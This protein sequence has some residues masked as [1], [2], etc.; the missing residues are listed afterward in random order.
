MAIGD[1]CPSCCKGYNCPSAIGDARGF[2][3]TLAEPRR[4]IRT[5]YA[6]YGELKFPA[7]SG[8][9]RGQSRAGEIKSLQQAR[10]GR[11]GESPPSGRVIF[12]GQSQGREARSRLS[13]MRSRKAPCR[14]MS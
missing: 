13:Q 12:S 5:G 10:E 9:L 7:C 8:M 3:P 6:I 4:V 1:Y 14:S 2:T 11:E